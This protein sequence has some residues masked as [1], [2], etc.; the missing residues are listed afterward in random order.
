MQYRCMHE[1]VRRKD[2][3][4]ILASLKQYISCYQKIK[5]FIFYL[6]ALMCADMRVYFNFINIQIDLFKIHLWYCYC[7]I[8]KY[9]DQ[10]Y[11]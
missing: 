4:S 7:F 1:R 6:K 10:R 9:T 11:V 5:K 3:Q 8:P 2:D